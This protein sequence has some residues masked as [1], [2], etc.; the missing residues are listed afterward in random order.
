MPAFDKAYSAV[1]APEVLPTWT[2]CIP[3][4]GAAPTVISRH[5]LQCRFGAMS[6]NHAD[7]VR[8][9]ILDRLQE[10]GVI[11]RSR[12]YVTEPQ[13]TYRYRCVKGEWRLYEN[14]TSRW[15]GYDPDFWEEV[16]T[17]D[18]PP[19]ILLAHAVDTQQPLI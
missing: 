16:L 18:V 8:S 11:Q 5:E 19:Q 6:Q 9:A 12:Y 1:T 17:I 2:W 15:T 3:A 14:P 10:V 7:M 13:A 4:P